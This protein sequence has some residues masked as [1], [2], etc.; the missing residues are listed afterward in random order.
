VDGDAGVCDIFEDSVVG[1]RGATEVVL[2]LEAVDGYDDVEALEVLP[3]SRN[4]AECAGHNLGVDAS[5]VK[6]GEDGFQFTKTNEGISSDEGDVKRFKFVDSFE[7]VSDQLVIFEIGQL[8]EGGISVSS[9][10]GGIVG[11]TSRAAQRT[12]SGNFYG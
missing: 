8:T 5:A 12:L 6:F 2:G 1:R 10:V 11:V 3:M 9:E 7:N 4:G